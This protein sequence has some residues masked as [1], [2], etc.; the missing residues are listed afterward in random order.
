[1]GARATDD[2][3]EVHFRGFGTA[4]AQTGPADARSTVNA[5]PANSA[6]AGSLR[7]G[8]VSEALAGTMPGAAGPLPE[9]VL[10]GL[11][12][13]EVKLMR[14]QMQEERDRMQ[15]MTQGFSAVSGAKLSVAVT[16]V[17]KD[18]DVPSFA[19]SAETTSAD[20]AAALAGALKLVGDEVTV[21]ASGNR[22]EARAKGYAAESGSLDGQALYRQALEGAPEQANAVIYVDV[23]RL[24]AGA[25][26][27][28]KER[29]QLKAVKAVGLAT[30][31]D[32]GDE[33]GLL[34]VIIK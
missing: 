7:V 11:P 28:E 16:K 15:A 6:I 29:G 9:E 25:D 13:G 12:P 31:I 17:G 24:L 2:G 27:T 33:V 10:E 8:D 34:R 14:K 20:K 26:M 23:Q 21:S 5:L 4:P 1:L 19:A 3:V 32:G 22:V 30:A 18:D